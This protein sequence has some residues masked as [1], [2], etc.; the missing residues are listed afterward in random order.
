M[1]D[2]QWNEDLARLM[3]AADSIAVL[4]RCLAVQQHLARWRTTGDAPQG[5][6]AAD[7]LD[8]ARGD[9]ERLSA[10]QAAD[11]LALV[12]RLLSVLPTPIE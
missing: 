6:L 12:E 4:S 5:Q 9:L 8:Q 3:N 1:E 2:A 10:G 7:A 11:L